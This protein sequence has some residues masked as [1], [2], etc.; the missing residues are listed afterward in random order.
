M[1]DSRGAR[2][3]SSAWESAISSNC[4]PMVKGL[5]ATLGNGGRDEIISGGQF[6][7]A[8]QGQKS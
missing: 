5:V 2:L 4:F 8:C 7:S 6:L 3:S 1:R